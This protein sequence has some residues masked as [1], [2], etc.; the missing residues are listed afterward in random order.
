MQLQTTFSKILWKTFVVICSL[1]LFISCEEPIDVT[2]APFDERPIIK[3]NF[4]I[5]KDS[6]YTRNFVYVRKSSPF[7]E[8]SYRDV[9]DALVTLRN[10]VTDSVYLFEHRSSGIYGIQDFNLKENTEYELKVVLDQEVFLS[11]ATSTNNAPI[12]TLEYV[13]DR[14]FENEEYVELEVGFKD[15]VNE[16]NY[17][18]FEIDFN[19]IQI[20]EDEFFNG[21][22]F[23]FSIFKLKTNVFE[24][25]VVVTSSGID[26]NYFTYLEKLIELN[27]PQFYGPFSAPPPNLRGNIIN[28]TNSNNLAFGYFQISVVYEKEYIFSNTGKIID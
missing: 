22:D 24:N 20:F 10:T 26:K 28:T 16:S 19:N 23:N 15:D 7:F 5:F 27:D 18:L 13:G 12:D 2:L 21:E 8:E 6:S 3:A 25:D 9:E 14:T 4:Q 1:T 17:Y 11:T